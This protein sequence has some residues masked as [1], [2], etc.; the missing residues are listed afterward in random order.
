[1][2][3]LK[4]AQHIFIPEIIIFLA[5][6]NQNC[7]EFYTLF[8]IF[9]RFWNA[10]VLRLYDNCYTQYWLRVYAWPQMPVGKVVFLCYIHVSLSNN[11]VILY[12][13]L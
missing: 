5:N 1:M 3:E 9:V 13:Y 12:I 7:C 11:N 10:H 4:G 8:K 6:T 2:K